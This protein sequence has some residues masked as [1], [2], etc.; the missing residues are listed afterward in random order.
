MSVKEPRLNE[1]A[2]SAL[3]PHPLN[4]KVF[5]SDLEDDIEALQLHIREHGQHKR[6]EI[7]PVAM[8][9]T[10]GITTP[11]GTIIKGHRCWFVATLE[12]KKRTPVIERWDLVG[13]PKAAELELL[14]DDDPSLKRKETDQMRVNRINEIRRLTGGSAAEVAEKTGESKPTVVRAGQIEKAV[15]TGNPAD[16]AEIKETL[17]TQGIR[18]AAEKAKVVNDS[19]ASNKTEKGKPRAPKN[20]PPVLDDRPPV[21]DPKKDHA[22]AKRMLVVLMNTTLGEELGETIRDVRKLI[23]ANDDE[24][25]TADILEGAEELQGKIQSFLTAHFEG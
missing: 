2:T 23:G 6:V 3:S 9:T 13:N 4:V 1:W 14:C 21:V 7:L 8:T 11:A 25:F 17:E 20:Q 19:V 12:G 16:V 5:G 22:R 18:P 10:K 24:E 15:E